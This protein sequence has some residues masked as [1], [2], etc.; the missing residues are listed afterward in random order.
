MSAS[1]TLIATGGPRHAIAWALR[2]VMILDRLRDACILALRQRVIATHHALQFGKFANHLRGQIRLGKQRRPCGKV[3]LGTNMGRDFAG[4][5]FQSLDPLALGAKLL[6]KDDLIELGQSVFQFDL[7]VGL[8]EKLGIGKP[9]LN[10]SSIAGGNRGA[11][12]GWPRYSPRA[13]I[14]C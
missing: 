12:I 9:C 5:A 13:R 10:D 1:A 3:T 14:Y 11:A 7:E 4:K 8:E 6:V 2:L